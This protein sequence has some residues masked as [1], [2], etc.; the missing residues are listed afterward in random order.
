[1]GPS[2]ETL[3]AALAV[4]VAGSAWGAFWIPLR[5]LESTGLVGPWATIGAELA[6]TLVMLPLALW[7]WRQ[8]KAGRPLLLMGLFG[9]IAF[10]LYNNA[11]LL[12]DVIRALLLFY[13]TPIWS[14]LL[15]RLFLGQPITIMR[16]ATIAMGFT[17]LIVVLGADGWLPIPTRVGD[18]M[19]L[20][21][22]ILWA[23]STVVIRKRQNI[24]AY[25]ATLSF[26]AVGVVASILMPLAVMPSA[27]TA[28]L[29]AAADLPRFVPWVILLGPIL[30]VPAQI[31]LMWGTKRLDPGRVGILLMGEVLVGAGTAAILTDEPFGW[32]EM[33]GSVLIVGAGLID[34]LMPGPQAKIV[35]TSSAESGARS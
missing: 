14:T 3:L 29:P 30:W 18:W 27:L 21:S 22:G 35:A 34:I 23:L 32:R 25:E 7:R 26:F 28:N 33:A 17:G 11:M 31:L 15:A 13:L 24:A 8:W 1:M 16:I 5:H 20:F 19:A 9:G 12:T 4:T 6:A 10:V 2:R